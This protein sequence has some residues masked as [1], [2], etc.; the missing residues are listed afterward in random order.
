L[1]GY[2]GSEPR[3]KSVVGVPHDGSVQ[4]FYLPVDGPDGAGRFR[5][6]PS[7][8]GPWGPAS[9][10]GGPPAA[11]LVRAVERL[12]R[13]GP[14]R[15][16]GRFTMELLGAVPVGPLRVEAHV[17][18]PGRTVELCEAT[19]F[20]EVY[21]GGR[22][23]ACARATAWL[24]PARDDGPDQAGRPPT[25]G[26]A[27]GVPRDLP[28]TWT[29][30]YLDAVE[31]SWITGAVTEPGPGV[32]W[33][34]PRVALVEGEP[35]SPVQRLMTCVDSAS[36]ASAALDPA[37]WDFMNTELTVHVLRP[38]VGDWVCLDALTTLGS[39]SVGVASSTV[40]DQRGV[41]ARS[42]QALLVAPRAS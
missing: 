40:L 34:R 32:V 19:L 6:T 15:V 29:H 39:G 24:F 12:E 27:D 41:V 18:R 30:G 16:V 10:H 8:V 37:R 3:A 38:P 23:R 14:P 13:Q 25:H 20:D 42:A 9:Q 26:P 7:T 35:M 17:T 4:P 5:S 31:W 36:G 11:L 22:G 28:P 2:T 21:D 1:E 33:M